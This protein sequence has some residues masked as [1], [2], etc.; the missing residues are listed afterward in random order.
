MDIKQDILQCAKYKAEMGFTFM[1]LELQAYVCSSEF[2][3]IISLC[4]PFELH[5]HIII[6]F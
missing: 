5:E 3:S 1:Y 6:I 4:L 2:K